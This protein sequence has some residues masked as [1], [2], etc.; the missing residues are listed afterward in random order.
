MQTWLWPLVPRADGVRTADA[1]RGNEMEI[2]MNVVK[3]D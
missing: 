3:F 1:L 2:R